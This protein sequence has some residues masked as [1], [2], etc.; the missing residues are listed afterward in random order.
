M[1]FTVRK[2]DTSREKMEAER[3]IATSFLHDWDEKEAAE[4]I[5]NPAGHAWGAFDEQNHMV[6]AITTLDREITFEGNVISCMELHMAGSLPE[7]RCGGA[8]RAQIDV[9]LKE[10]RDRGDLFAL[11]IPFSFVFYRK[12]GFEAASEMLIQKAEIGQFEGFEQIFAA[13]QILSQEKVNELR[14]LYSRFIQCFNMA[15][16]KTEADWTYH[17]NGEFGRRDWQNGDKMHYSYLFRGPDGRARA[18]FTFVFIHGSQGPFWGTMEVTELVFDS[19]EALQSV[20]SFIYG[21]RAKITH[22]TAELPRDIDWSFMLPECDRVERKLDGH[23]TARVL[24]PSKVLAAMRHPEGK[25]QYSI[26]ITDDFLTE[27]TGTYTVCFADGKATG[28]TK[29]EE[30]ADLEITIQT[31]CQLAV[32]LTNLNTAL[33]RKGTLLRSKGALLERLFVKRPLFLK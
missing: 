29:G 24:N 15:D 22:V 19:P 8:I 17:E 25:G 7:A 21:M 20:F 28:V 14:E 23:Y 1:N 13:E 32:G 16:V 4:N 18:Y 11:L 10:C 9:I 2:L 26:R 3:L 5:E 31:F 27:N 33:Y 12:Y 6:S 30:T